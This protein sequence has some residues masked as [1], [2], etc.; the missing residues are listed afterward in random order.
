MTFLTV[1]IAAETL[2][3]AKGLIK[4]ASDSGAEMLELRTDFLNERNFAI[5]EQLI[6]EIKSRGLPVIVTCRDKKQGGFRELP[7]E[8][9]TEV[10]TAALKSGADYVDCEFENFLKSEVQS[11]LT[12]AAFKFSGPP[13]PFC[14]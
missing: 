11:A 12:G 14:A 3:E 4:A 5:I 8:I 2:D 13:D 6:S 10:L 9:R 1:P 7:Q